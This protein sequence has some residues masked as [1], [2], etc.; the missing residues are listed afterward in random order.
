MHLHVFAVFVFCL[1]LALGGCNKDEFQSILEENNV[2]GRLD[3]LD[4][5]AQTNDSQNKAPRLATVCV[6]VCKYACV[7]VLVLF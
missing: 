5:D 1:N 4:A 2:L 3:Q 6:C 7:L